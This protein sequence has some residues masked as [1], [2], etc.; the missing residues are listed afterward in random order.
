MSRYTLRISGEDLESVRESL[1]ATEGIHSSPSNGESVVITVDAPSHEEAVAFAR[2]A[3]PP[4][5]YAI[6][7]PAALED[8]AD[9]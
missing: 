1:A 8:D 4:G 3:L 6:S 9:E 2:E 7:R 5:D